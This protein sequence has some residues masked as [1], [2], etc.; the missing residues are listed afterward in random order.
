MRVAGSSFVKP[1]Q[2]QYGAQVRGF[3]TASESLL[4]LRGGQ[5]VRP[6]MTPR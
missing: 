5:C 6:C 1:L 2:E 4:A 3:R